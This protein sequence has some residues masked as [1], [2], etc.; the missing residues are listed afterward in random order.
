MKY[1]SILIIVDRFIKY[2]YFLPYQK[3]AN[4]D[5]LV[6][7]FL[8]VIVGNHGLPDKIV[9]DRDKLV[10]FKFWQSL[11]WQ[12]GSKHKLFTTAHSQTDGQIEQTNQTLKQYL[13]CYINYQQN[14][15]VELLPL[16]QFAYNSTKTEATVTTGLDN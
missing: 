7:T 2:T 9:S 15:W 3:T 8:Q 13:H 16:A 6:Y 14:N 1:N 4:I 12:L 10:I 5:D 11:T